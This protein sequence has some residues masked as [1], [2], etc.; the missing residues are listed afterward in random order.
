MNNRFQE[1]F[2][3]YGNEVNINHQSPQKLKNHITEKYSVIPVENEVVEIKRIKERFLL[4]LENSLEVT[5]KDKENKPDIWF[6]KIVQD[7]RS[8]ELYS[9]KINDWIDGSIFILIDMSSGYFQTNSPI[10]STQIIEYVGVTK[11]DIKNMSFRYMNYLIN[12]E[13]LDIN[14]KLISGK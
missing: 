13:Q 10:L 12:R 7:E 1:L 5:G 8:E 6:V 4:N 11:D 9:C 14:N 2:N 3:K